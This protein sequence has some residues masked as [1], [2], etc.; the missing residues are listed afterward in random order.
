MKTA[1]REAEPQ[2]LSV[3]DAL[4]RILERFA[5][6]PD[7]E[8]P[9][10]DAL[11]QVLA[12]DVRAPND[13][14]PFANSAMDGY[15][16]RAA[17]V[18]RTP[19]RLP[20]AF[21]VAAGAAGDRALASGAAARIMTGAPLPSGA[22]SVVRVEDTDAGDASVE[23]RVGV[24][25]GTNVRAAGEDL[26]R[27]ETVFARGTVLRAAEIGVLA[28]TG[29]ASVRVVRR[30]RVAVLSTGDE[31]VEVDA[32]LAPGKIRDANRWS[33]SAAVNACGAIAVP[34]GI[35]R[36]NAD[37]LRRAFR[38]AAQ[39]DVIVT[40]GGVSVGDYDFVKV[41][42]RELGSMDFWTIAMRPGKPVAFGDVL[43]KP[44]LGLPGNPVSALLTFELFG[45]PALLRL[46]GR[47]KL[48]RPRVTARLIEDVQKPPHLRFFGRAIYD[49]GGGTVR[50]TGPQGSGILR[51]MALANALVDLPIGPAVVRAGS[52][53][54]VILT[55][56]PE[57]H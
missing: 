36:D 56:A 19:V 13:V 45:R 42:V 12:E 22:D 21:E 20:V 37:D 38:R 11:G 23:I 16:V 49:P 57:D 46:Q 47:A 55:D 54:T 30:P 4:A 18:A 32:P 9:I 10:L 25:A 8:K 3:D 28:T 31:V 17:D 52:E 5:P 43:G 2:A 14:P 48:H 15:A 24:P 53:V 39:E 27:G 29:R 1:P 6:L 7:E 50:T 51:S 41:V 26:R 40:S 35:A 34:L 44:I 33:I